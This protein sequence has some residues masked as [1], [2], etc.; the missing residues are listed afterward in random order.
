MKCAYLFPGQ[1]AQYVGMGKDFYDSFSIARDTFTEADDIL[2]E[3]LSKII[4]F[5]PQDLLTET[6]WAQ[7]GIFVTSMAIFR[8]VRQERPDLPLSVCA[9]L[10]LGEYTALSASGRL[11]FKETLL[12]VQKRAQLMNEA[13]GKTEGTMAA[14]IGL[15]AA[16]IRE[17]LEEC[18]GVWV[19]NFNAPGQT[20]I[21]G[22]LEGVK[23]MEPRLKARGAKR[24]FP[25]KVHGAFHSPL[26]Q[27][28]QD[29]LTPFLKEAPIQESSVPFV[30]NVSG[31]FV[32]GIEAVREH[33][34]TQVTQSVCWE[35][36]VEAMK[37]RQVDFYLEVGCG[38]TLSG[39]NK[40]MDIPSMASIDKVTD[41]ELAHA[42]T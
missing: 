12:L 27:L 7:L 26:M 32:E 11:S 19:A 29:G 16:Q 30:M 18:E 28:A 13:C 24:I 23:R 36:G 10:S 2:G 34:R 41:L 33:L 21:T 31:S 6:Q 9:G 17:E 15:D 1:G 35:Q 37:E 22:T 14:V 5:G 40:K 39:L 38:K 4:F 42:I 8:V 20:V 25:L 3:N